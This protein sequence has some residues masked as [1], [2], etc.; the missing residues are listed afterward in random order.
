[1]SFDK[2]PSALAGL[3]A[4][5][6]AQW[7]QMGE[8][9]RNAAQLIALLLSLALLWF[10]A[11]QPAWRTLN[12]APAQAESL[13]RQL[14]DMQALAQEAQELRAAP[15]V[16]AA[17][18]TQALQAASEHLGP[19]ARLQINGD[20]AVLMLNGVSSEALQAWL[21][22][23]RS[24]ARARP[25]EAKLQRSPQGFNGSIVLSLQGGSAP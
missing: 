19:A 20:R 18:A 12:Q 9:E 4:Q 13:E 7:Q 15:T 1:M 23:A 25:L 6:Q 10:V 24:A 2:K 14:Q 16:P 17:Q 11:V 22:E 5:A 21:G 8:R 3:Q